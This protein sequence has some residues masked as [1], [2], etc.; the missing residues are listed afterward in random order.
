[1]GEASC[2][3]CG[4]R[5]RLAVSA[6]SCCLLLAAA[7][8]ALAAGPLGR[9][10]EPVTTSDYTIDLYQGPVLAGSRVVGLAGA[11]TPIASGV[12]GYSYNP[13]AVAHREPW[14]TTWLDWE[15]DGGFTLPTS[16]TD[17]DFDNNGDEGYANSAA[18]F[19]TGGLGLQFGDLGVG[20]NVD[21]Q[22]YQLDSKQ[23]PSRT[24]NVTVSRVLLVGGYSFLDGELIAGLGLSGSKVDI[25]HAIVI[26]ADQSEE[27]REVGSAAG[28]AIHLGL[29]WAPAYAPLRIGVATRLS[30]AEW[31]AAQSPECQPPGCLQQD[32]DFISEGFYLPRA[33]ALPTEI[34]AGIAVQLLRPLNIPW[35]NPHDEPGELQRVQAQIERERAA[36]RLVFEGRMRK[37][38]L[39]GRDPDPIEDELEQAE[40][41]AEP[42]EDERLDEARA[43]DRW[44]RLLP[45]RMMPRERILITAAMKLTTSTEAGVG[46]ESFLEQEVERSGEQITVQPRLAI[47]A[48]AIPGYLVLRAGGYLEP[49]RFAAGSS[50]LHGTGGLDVRIPIE[51]SA[52]GLLDD[53]TTFRISGAVDGTVR[54]FGWGAGVGLWH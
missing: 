11:Y 51:W 36:R 20:F 12:A 46:L 37:A 14:S 6:L 19:G 16:I 33:I 42:D 2:F 17:F 35:V 49:S 15:L 32:G 27:E 23:D 31:T 48:E 26:G 53:D 44:R 24:L 9:D 45:Y 30:P 13:A 34:H 7:A 10:G 21:L 54:Y 52:F 25:D 40:E 47:E 4:F 29:L 38:E 41:E 39:A 5:P 18:F 50:R 3:G 28:P 1:V 8:P 43:A 22:L